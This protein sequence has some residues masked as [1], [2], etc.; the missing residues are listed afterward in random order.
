MYFFLYDMH[1]G[2]R[3]KT[4]YEIIIMKAD[5]EKHLA[6]LFDRKFDRSIYNVTCECCGSDFSIQEFKTKKEAEEYLKH[7]REK[8]IGKFY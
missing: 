3:Q 6:Y 5:N 2:G 7:Y 8:N 4:P 1:S